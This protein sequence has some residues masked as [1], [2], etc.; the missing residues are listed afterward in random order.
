[1][2]YRQ[3]PPCMMWPQEAMLNMNDA[4]IDEEDE[5][6][7][8]MLYPKLYHSVMPLVMYQGD[9]MELRYGAMYCPRRDELGKITD[10][11]YDRIE[12][13]INFDEYD[14]GR[15]ENE[16]DNEHRGYYRNNEE[17]AR[18][19]PRR[20]ERSLKDL[21]EILFLRDLHR[22][23]RRRRRRRPYQGGY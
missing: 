17:E 5:Q 16:N 11:I 22:R 20:R 9:Q 15:D 4:M 2:Y 3:I 12:K 23:R 18:Q 19:R 13:D 10:D 7:L 14:D 6:D 8:A 21:I 1:M